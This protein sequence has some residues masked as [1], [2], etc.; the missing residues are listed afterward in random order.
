M[1]AWRTGS[2]RTGE[3]AS[4]GTAFS[5]PG[6]RTA[7]GAQINR[8]FISRAPGRVNLIGEHTDYNDG[9]VCPM[10]LDRVTAVLAAPRT[11]GMVRLH[12]LSVGETV[13]FPIDRPV[14]KE[15]PAWSLYPRGAAEAMRQRAKISLG[16]DA[17]VD[18]SVPL[19]GGLSS[20][21]SFEVATANAVLFA[22][23]Q[24]LPLTELALACQWAEHNYPGMPCGIMDQ[25]ISTMGRKGHAL[26]LD[27]RDRS[28]RQVPLDDPDLRVVISNSNV[29]RE[30][31]AGEY[32]ARRHYC[33]MAVAFLKKKIPGVQSLRDVSLDLLEDSRLG[34]DPVVFRRAHHV[35]SEIQRTADFAAALEKRR[36]KLCGE[37]MYASHASLRDDYAV[38]CTELDALVEIARAVPGVY[39]ARMTGGGFGGCIVALCAAA[40]VEPL[41]AAIAAEYPAKTKG[42]QATT[43]STVASAG[44]S[45]EKV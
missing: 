44:A 21:A 13:E 30:L 10:A 8:L 36:Y 34:M 27:C 41:T 22:N 2:Y 7:F 37:L 43:F 40:A 3:P 28:T 24:Q 14:P 4:G 32:A 42:K 12:S 23:N 17:V 5:G 38:S 15:G 11:D 16:F 6:S 18:S 31:V 19:G 45:V 25:F 29:K 33:Q 20:S 9:F 35:I 1:A 39:G 26:L